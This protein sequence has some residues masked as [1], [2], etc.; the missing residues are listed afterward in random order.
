MDTQRDYS[1]LN[2]RIYEVLSTGVP[3]ITER[4]EVLEETFGDWCTFYH[5]GVD[6]VDKER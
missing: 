5:L 4:F 2:N 1:M 3:L 6:G